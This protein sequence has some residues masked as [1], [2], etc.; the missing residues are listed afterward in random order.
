MGNFII[1]LSLIHVLCLVYYRLRFLG[2]QS[3]KMADLS[4]LLFV[5]LL[6]YKKHRHILLLLLLFV[7]VLHLLISQ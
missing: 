7:S 1:R 6:T 2:V 5:S 4:M 3:G